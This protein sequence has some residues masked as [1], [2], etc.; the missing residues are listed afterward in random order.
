[1]R[2]QE[3]Y[4]SIPS[5]ED[6]FNGAKAVMKTRDMTRMTDRVLP[7]VLG[8]DVGAEFE[9]ALGDVDP[10]VE[11][12]DVE[13]GAVV[14]V[15]GVDEAGV[16]LQELPHRRRVVLVGV[17]QDQRRPAHPSLLPLLRRRRRRRRRRL[18][19]A[20]LLPAAAHL[21]PS[22]SLVVYRNRIDR[23]SYPTATFSK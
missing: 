18:R 20:R 12:G 22:L 21:S 16:F 10:A 5:Q 4:D 17:P 11:R 2:D 9:E 3:Q 1:M 13:R 7:T 19:P 6:E 14:V 15:A 23:G 8:I